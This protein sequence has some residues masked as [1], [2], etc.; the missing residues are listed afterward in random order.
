MREPRPDHAADQ[1]DQSRVD[2]SLAIQPR[3]IR[4]VFRQV[5]GREKSDDHHQSV[6]VEVNFM[7]EEVEVE[8]FGK[9]GDWSL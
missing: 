5:D 7:A 2:K 9:H 6:G 3:S 1:R 4:Q 8:E